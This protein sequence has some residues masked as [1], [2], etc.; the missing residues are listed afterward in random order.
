MAHLRFDHSSG[1]LTLLTGVT[2]RAARMGHRLT[3]RMNEWS[4]DVE[5]A[6]GIPKTATV[7]IPVS[8]L[9]VVSGEGGVKGLSGPE[10]SL[11]RGNALK[12]L[13]ADRFPTISYACDDIQQTD[14]GYVMH[15]AATICNVTRALD[16]PVTVAAES[17]GYG[18]GFRLSVRQSD[19]GVEP[20][21]LMM[22][23]VQVEDDIQVDWQAAVPELA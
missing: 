11:A 18:L 5:F 10:K 6:R 9:E 15:G 21:S 7:T 1:S 14:S 13:G 4:A 8:G 12:T 19:F 23:S 3:I 16:V 2:G 20:Y 22:G 17:D